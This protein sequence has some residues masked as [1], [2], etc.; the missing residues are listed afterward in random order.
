MQRSLFWRSLHLFLGGLFFYSPP[1]C[2]VA[3]IHI[4]RQPSTKIFPK[5]LTETFVCAAIMG[6]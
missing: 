1:A 6:N 5:P 3:H 2:P 4:F